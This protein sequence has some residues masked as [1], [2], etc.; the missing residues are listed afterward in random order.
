MWMG[1]K[2]EGF[3]IVGMFGSYDNRMTVYM[4][5]RIFDIYF[6]VIIILVLPMDESL[7]KQHFEIKTDTFL[8]FVMI[9]IH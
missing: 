9:I 7:I 8:M 4:L 5:L 6:M 1:I 3:T 2:D